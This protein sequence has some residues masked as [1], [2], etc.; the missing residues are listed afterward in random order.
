[1]IK[2]AEEDSTALVV[3]MASRFLYIISKELMACATACTAVMSCSRIDFPV[4]DQKY[5]IE[6]V[7]N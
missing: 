4:N 2:M 3:Y 5:F 6:T 1:M 7:K